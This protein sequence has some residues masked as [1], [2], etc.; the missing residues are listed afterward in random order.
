[1]LAPKKAS[2]AGIHQG[3]PGIFGLELA[4]AR[5]LSVHVHTRSQRK[6]RN[7]R[8]PGLPSAHTYTT[9]EGKKNACGPPGYGI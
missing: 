9:C 4:A 6:W 8:E 2:R 3:P 1:M 5:A 7:A